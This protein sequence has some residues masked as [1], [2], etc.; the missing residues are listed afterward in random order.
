MVLP[1]SLSASLTRTSPD[2]SFGRSRSRVAARVR[3]SNLF[4]SAWSI[5]GPVVSLKTAK[6]RSGGGDEFGR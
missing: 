5:N 3:F 1:T 6:M 2:M 4:A